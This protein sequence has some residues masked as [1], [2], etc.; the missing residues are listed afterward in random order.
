MINLYK[1][2]QF[3]LREDGI[4]I[5]NIGPFFNSPWIHKKKNAVKV[6]EILHLMQ[7]SWGAG[8]IAMMKGSLNDPPC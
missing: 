3:E 7:L 2:N 5:D 1:V 4:Y 6:Y 8:R